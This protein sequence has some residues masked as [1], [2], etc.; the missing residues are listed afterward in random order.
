MTEQLTTR[1]M[2]ELAA[3]AA[4]YQVVWSNTF[5]RFERFETSESG[6]QRYVGP[7]CPH[8]DDGDSKRLAVSLGIDV[9]HGI[10][11]VYAISGHGADKIDC[12]ARYEHHNNNADAAWRWAVLQVAAQIGRSMP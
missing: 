1:Q 2:L 8:E 3:K 10:H 9:L 5:D 11:D 4:G 7:F 6:F 12:T